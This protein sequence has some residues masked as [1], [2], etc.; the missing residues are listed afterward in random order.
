ME[1]EGGWRFGWKSCYL[2]LFLN[3]EVRWDM[4]KGLL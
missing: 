3:A 1:G 4:E 2:S